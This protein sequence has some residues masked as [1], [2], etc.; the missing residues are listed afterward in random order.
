[1]NRISK[2]I[3]K[4]YIATF[5]RYIKTLYVKMEDHMDEF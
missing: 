4:C 5:D 3:N 2:E 1:M